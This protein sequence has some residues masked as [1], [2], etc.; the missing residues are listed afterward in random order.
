L[1]RAKLAGTEPALPA[2]ALQYADVAIRQRALSDEIMAGQLAYWTEHLA[3]AP[4][5]LELPTDRVRPAV[6]TTRGAVIHAAFPPAVTAA[7]RELSKRSGVTLF[8]TL[9]AAY[10]TLLHRYTGQSDLVVGS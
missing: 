2:L 9:L 7:V 4:E 6:H 3:G 1:V 5:L 10:Y 8:M